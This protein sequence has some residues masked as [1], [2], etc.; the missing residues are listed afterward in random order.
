[1]N[2][3]REITSNKF[4][5]DV[6]ESLSILWKSEA[7]N[8][9]LFIKNT[10]I[11]LNPTFSF[12]I[13]KQWSKKGITM[14]SDFLGI[15]NVV[16]PIDTFMETY[17][18]KTNF[19]E[20]HHISHKIKKFIEWRDMPL[21]EED[22]PKNSS[23]NVFLNQTV[24]GVSKI[25]SQ[26]KSSSSSVLDTAVEKWCANSELD[27]NS[28]DL[29]RSLQKHH[30]I[31]KDT[32]LKYIQFR[33]LHHRFF[34]NEKLFKMGIKD[35]DLCGFCHVHS[36]SIEHMFLDCEISIDLW[37]EVQEWIHTL[38]MDNYNLSQSRIIL[39]DL[40]N[41]MSINTIILLTKKVIYNSMKKEQRPH[42]LTLK[43]R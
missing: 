38:G 37:N 21:F 16:M 36:D 1:M 17:G 29:S 3:L 18:L 23:L 34:T 25:Y 24:K 15:M 2:K 43:M 12:P 39:G 8:E 40:E 19:L 33:T 32:Y 6:I 31:Y 14:V 42:I 41:A 27:F 9:K 13:N 5:L 28:F 35:S 26:I 20:Y 10:P 7:M 4:W 22:Q 30:L 11:W